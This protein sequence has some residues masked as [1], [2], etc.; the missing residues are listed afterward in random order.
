MILW[1]LNIGK[2]TYMPRI[3]EAISGGEG[4]DLLVEPQEL[5]FFFQFL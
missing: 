2:Y 5:P 3:S 4:K 1:Y